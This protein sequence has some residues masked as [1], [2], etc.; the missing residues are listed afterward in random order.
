MR[1][2]LTI[3][4]VDD[5]EDIRR[6]LGVKLIAEGYEVIKAKDGSEA[7]RKAKK[8]V[9]D[10]ILMDILMSDLDGSQIVK[11][12]RVDDRTKEIPVIF[13]TGMLTPEETQSEST[14]L[15]VDNIFYPTLAKP[16]N[17]E[18]LLG[19]IDEVFYKNYPN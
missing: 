5:E 18:T 19:A 15:R 7:L 9:P 11:M 8:F 16:F 10:L 17:A 12:L 3:L 4:I 2:I 13:L 1:S 14:G 6:V